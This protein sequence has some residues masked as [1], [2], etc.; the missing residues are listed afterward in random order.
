MRIR[1]SL[2]VPVCALALILPFGGPM[3]ARAQ[4]SDVLGVRSRNNP[5]SLTANFKDFFTNTI[6]PDMSITEGSASE[7]VTLSSG[8]NSSFFET[9]IDELGP[10]DVLH[11]R[12][13]GTAYLMEPGAPG[14]VSDMVTVTV[15]QVGFETL[16]WTVTLNSDPFSFPTGATGF[17]ESGLLQ[18]V[19]SDIFIA[20]G[21]ITPL[22]PSQS[23]L[24]P[25][26]VV[27]ESDV[28]EPGTYALLGSLGLTG[29]AFL[30][31][32]RAR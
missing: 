26:D 27:V 17:T 2:D 10:N 13:T 20:S 29:A 5:S 30:R 16:D 19:S 24:F 23:I 22:D 31:R 1:G 12:R 15:T 25:F 28:P 4:T 32:R 21:L 6:V 11:L 8:S 18:D 7:A 9:T 14:V 3:C